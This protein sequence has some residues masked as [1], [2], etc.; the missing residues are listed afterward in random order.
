MQALQQQAAASQK[1]A[2]ET[3]AAAA[4][5]KS[6]AEEAQQARAEAAALAAKNQAER[7]AIAAERDSLQKE[8]DA[9][10]ANLVAALSKIADTKRT[11]RGI[12]VTLPGSY[13][14][15]NNELTAAAKSAVSR[16][17]SN[18]ASLARQQSA[19]RGLLRRRTRRG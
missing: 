12:V 18:G 7:D 1:Q 17:A 6:M 2:T 3:A 9:M 4:E 8:R 5:A 15:P 19:H 11:A 13:F 16:L 14:G 10:A